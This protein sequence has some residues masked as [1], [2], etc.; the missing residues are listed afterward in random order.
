MYVV[1]LGC[2]YYGAVRGPGE[3]SCGIS[4]MYSMTFNLPRLRQKILAAAG[5]SRAGRFFCDS[6]RLGDLLV[7]NIGASSKSSLKIGRR[8]LE[9]D[10]CQPTLGRNHPFQHVGRKR[11]VARRSSSGN[12]RV[13]RGR[14]NGARNL[15]APT[16]RPLDMHI[17]RQRIQS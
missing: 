8:A 7:P 10:G 13:W 16:G 9:I 2:D 15:Q 1:F 3:P 17:T 14:R 5:Y 4:L 12:I 6:Q 11:S